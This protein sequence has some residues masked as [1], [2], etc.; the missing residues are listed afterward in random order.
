MP[1]FLVLTLH[2]SSLRIKPEAL[3]DQSFAIF[4]LDF[5]TETHKTVVQSVR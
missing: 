1:I 2:L 3:S 4:T 5:L